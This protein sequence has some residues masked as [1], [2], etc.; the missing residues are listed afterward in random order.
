MLAA[1]TNHE[2]RLAEDGP[3]I[4]YST[5]LLESIRRLAVDG[6]TA[7]SHGGLEAGGVLYGMREGD[8]LSVLSFAELPCEHALGP[9][10][11]LS[12]NDRAA[13]VPLLQPPDGFE[14]VGWFRVHTR[15][16]VELDSHDRK[17]FDAFAPRVPC[18]AL[19]VKP[20]AW[21]PATAAFFVREPDGHVIPPSP[22]EFL[23][24]PFK[25][26]RDTRVGEAT[27]A[28][29]LPAAEPYAL[30]VVREPAPPM[31]FRPAVERS[32]RLSLARWTLGAAAVICILLA[33]LFW[34]RPSRRLS[35]AVFA[36]APGQVRIEWNRGSPL[37]LGA[38]S[39]VLRIDDG[40]H[41]ERVPLDS[42]QLRSTSI[43]YSQRSGRITVRL[44]VQGKEPDAAPVEESV[45][46]VG[47]PAPAR[48]P[49]PRAA[50]PD[51][52]APAAAKEPVIVRVPLQE[53]LPA[54]QGE[55]SRTVERAARSFQ[56]PR[57]NPPAA[58]T[59]AALP[60]PPPL[61][62]TTAGAA[63]DL[64]SSLP[65]PSSPRPSAPPAPPAAVVPV[66]PGPRSGRM[67][68]TGVLGRRGI[69]EIEGGRATVGS[70][71]GA[72]PGAPVSLRIS[73][74]E[75]GRTGLVVFTGDASNAGRYEPPARSNGWNAVQFQMDR[76]RAQGLVVLESP[77]R[78]N[79]FNRLVLRSDL[80]NC[81]VIVIDWST[82]PGAQPGN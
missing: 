6:L 30:E 38:Q 76:E 71:T 72:L 4:G 51:P 13:L 60:A 35:L 39:G 32:R 61:A 18:V 24:Q 26:S 47:P 7:F 75:F 34:P 23:L 40:S 67:I 74:A 33:A 79:D 16:G 55:A 43:T 59:T 11:V 77:N 68:W 1:G 52:P 53:A 48:A 25:P 31:V 50:A 49:V 80:R 62:S 37:V 36:V 81:P 65:S 5:A 28:S 21:G 10:F 78:S 8:A 69:V 45:Q 44:R 3:P 54:R 63:A 2:M 20:T 42:E 41:N 66:D 14:T 70:L 9:G 15:S 56:M 29:A 46:F 64:L 58:A 73:P 19:I 27:L 57:T 82:Q 22:R 12:D 17:L